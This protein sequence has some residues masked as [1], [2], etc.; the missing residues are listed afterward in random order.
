M[1]RRETIRNRPRW[2]PARLFAGLAVLALSVAACGPDVPALVTALPSLTVSETRLAPISTITAPASATLA[3]SDT[4]P[5]ATLTDPASATP[6]AS[7]TAATP[8]ASVTSQP[9]ATELALTPDAQ[10]L[11]RQVKLPIL[12]YH[13]V[14]PWPANATPLRKALTVQPAD[15]AAQMAYLHAQGYVTV[16]LYDLMS[17]L[18]Q[19]TS[20][21]QRAVVLTFDD[22]Y[23]TLM[24]YAAPALAPL[25]YTGTVFVITQLMDENFAQYLTWPQAEALYAAG[26]KIE[27]HTKTHPIL[28]GQKRDFQLYEIL[29]SVQ[30]VAAHIGR[31]PRFF[32]YPY[33]KWDD[34]TI[35]LEREMN[36]W[37]AVTE[38]PGDVHAYSTRY[39]LHRVRVN[40]TMT[41]ADFIQTI[42]ATQ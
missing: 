41:L 33:G 10:A 2:L 20:L 39:G 19:G 15:F 23:R 5:A 3:P 29:G 36:L 21:P 26:W 30:T 6:S 16:S 25:G 42:K 14:E 4:P 12:L 35:E 32:A 8:A 24:D 38:L 27:P 34:T 31:M 13:Y 18:A 11:G 40:G 28:A 9:A 1:H 22:G 17:A 7:P 37:G